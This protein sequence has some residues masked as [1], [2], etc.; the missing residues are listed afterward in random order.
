MLET[1]HRGLLMAAVMSVSIIQFLDMT[2]ANVALPHI[3]SG[4]GASL[5]S[6]SWVLT[7]YIIAAVMFTPIVGW[8]S[9]KLGSRRVFL[10]AVA[11]FLLASAAAAEVFVLAVAADPAR[12]D[13]HGR[14]LSPSRSCADPP[15]PGDAGPA[16]PQLLGTRLGCAQRHVQFRSHHLQDVQGHDRA[17]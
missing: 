11:G 5:D 9:D 16:R 1:R 7:S 12:T 3:R 8:L 13:D 15:D 14:Q 10:G 2:I 4:L 6:I 17:I